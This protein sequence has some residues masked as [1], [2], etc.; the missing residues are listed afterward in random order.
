MED[1][2]MKEQEETKYDK[3]KNKVMGDMGSRYKTNRV[4]IFMYKCRMAFY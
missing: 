3:E 4:R 2:Q 1:I